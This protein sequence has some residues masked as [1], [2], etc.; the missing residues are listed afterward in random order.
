MLSSTISLSMRPVRSEVERAATGTG[1]TFRGLKKAVSGNCESRFESKLERP[2]I[3]NSTDNDEFPPH[4]VNLV[5]GTGWLFA[6]KDMDA[7]LDY[8]FI[9]EA[10]QISGR[11]RRDRHGSHLSWP[12]EGGQWQLRVAL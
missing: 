4:G 9:D 5:A 7:V 8:L 11:A 1:V 10:G 12:E 6:R 3:E 2:L